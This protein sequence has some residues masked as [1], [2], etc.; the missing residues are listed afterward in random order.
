ML[1]DK[2]I[3]KK[4]VKH[5][6]FMVIFISLLLILG[7]LFFGNGFYRLSS[8]DCSLNNGSCGSCYTDNPSD[9]LQ[10]DEYTSLSKASQCKEGGGGCHIFTSYINPIINV[11]SSI[12]VLVAIISI[13]L[14][15]IMYSSSGGD[16]QKTAKAKSRIINTL[17][18]LLAYIFLYSFLQFLI[19]GGLLK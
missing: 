9:C 16:P 6:F 8:S 2:Q 18:A 19:P 1:K 13:I 17:I 10:S 11:L 7:S 12:I 14:A 4:S 3:F 15:G 5:S